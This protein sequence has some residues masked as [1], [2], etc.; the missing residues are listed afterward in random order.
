MVGGGG[1]G[2]ALLMV[3][4]WRVDVVLSDVSGCCD[5]CMV[6]ML[7]VLYGWYDVVWLVVELL[8]LLL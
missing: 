3:Y 8:L 4:D 5:C 6:G 7:L 1:G 2:G